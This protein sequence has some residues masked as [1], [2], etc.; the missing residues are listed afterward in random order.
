[1][2]DAFRVVKTALMQGRKETMGVLLKEEHFPGLLQGLS[3]KCPSI[4]SISSSE[5]G[6]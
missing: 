2:R 5:I 1:M 3:C 4:Q 6:G